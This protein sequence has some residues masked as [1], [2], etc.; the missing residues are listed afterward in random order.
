MAKA[1]SL[2][3]IA[4]KAGRLEIGERSVETAAR[5]KRARVILTASDAAEKT[6]R[7]A[8]ELSRNANTLHLALPY[9]KDEIGREL[10]R[11]AVAVVAVSD[12]GI[13]AALVKRLAAECPGSYDEAALALSE[14]SERMLRR[15]REKS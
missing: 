7:H 15:R 6:G 11:D 8:E 3:G 14:K 5:A 12:M 13:A 10:G 2:L 4:K 9:T 1:V